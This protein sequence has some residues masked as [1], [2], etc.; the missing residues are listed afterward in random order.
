LINFDFKELDGSPMDFNSA[1]SNSMCHAF[2]SLLRQ[3][4]SMYI[5]T[6]NRLHGIDTTEATND[7]DYAGTL[8]DIVGKLAKPEGEM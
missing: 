1:N 4:D 6:D 7:G 5:G 3:G 2:F 8:D